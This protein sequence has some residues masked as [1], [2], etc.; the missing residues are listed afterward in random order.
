MSADDALLF[1]DANVYLDLYRTVSGKRLLAPLAEQAEH[2]FV[3]QQV[4]NEVKRRKIEVAAEFLARHFT[5]LKLQTYA[6][7]DHL[8]GIE[9]EENK[10]IRERMKK[11]SDETKELNNELA[12]LAKTIM[13]KIAR[14]QDEVSQALAT[15][16]RTAVLHN[17]EELGRA[18]ERKERGIPPGKAGDPIGDQ[19]TWEQVRSAF[20]GKKRLW[21]ISR[22]GDYGSVYEGEGWLNEVLFEE[23]RE[24]SPEAGAFY[25]KDL[26]D[27]IADFA[28]ATGVTAEKLPS[29]EEAEKIR[30]EERRLPPL[31]WLTS[32]TDTADIVIANAL[33]RS[34]RFA[35]A[36]GTGTIYVPYPPLDRELPNTAGTSSYVQPT[37]GTT[38]ITPGGSMDKE[39]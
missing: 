13:G 5:P 32:G 20:K 3:T 38:G 9:E 10:K 33:A 30:D 34:R 25:F 7:P 17:S 21:V 2:I 37:Q 39:P 24:I 16:F 19:L 29:P 6:V 27:G 35:A 15:V 1:I 28:R 26:C 36:I 11:V 14:S 8:F 31:G 12:T 18:K 4:V 22:D 23:L